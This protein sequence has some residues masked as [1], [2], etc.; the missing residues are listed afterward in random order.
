M[1]PA[2]VP[3]VTPRKRASRQVRLRRTVVVVA[4]A[5]AGG[6][7]FAVGRSPTHAS[8][9]N[10]T[11]PHAAPT[12]TN[13]FVAPKQPS[14]PAIYRE[15]V[16][17]TLGHA[18]ADP[19]AGA[20]GT[21]VVFAGGLDASTTSTARIGSISGRTVQSLANLPAAFHDSAGAAIDNAL[22]L[23]GGGN[24][25]SQL[26]GIV[27]VDPNGAAT[28]VGR[29]P[30]PS[31]DSLAATIG[32]TAYVVG[33]YTGAR[34]LDTIVAYDPQ[35][36][37]RIVAHL[38]VGLRYAAVAAAGGRIV[39]AGG[40][41]PVA[42]AS[43]TIYSFDPASG[44]VTA[45]GE[46]PQPISHAAAAGVGNE[47]L[48]AGG[49][50]IADQPQDSITAINPGTHRVRAAGRLTTARSDAALVVAD[51]KPLLIG[52]KSA[53]STL[54][55]VSELV[56][57]D[58]ATATNV[59]AHDT[60]NALSPVAA[61]ARPLIY[62]PNSM[63][64]TVDVIDP[65]TYTVI[66]QFNVGALPQHV[67]PAW[68][69]RT[70]YVDNDHGNSLTPI[71]PRTGK[72]RGPD[73]P[74][75]D[76]YNLYFTTDG[77]DAI[78]VAEARGR[79]DFRDP[80]SFKLVKSVPVPC[81]GVD[82]MDYTA[83]GKLALA[84][85]EFSGQMI[86]VD[87]VH[88]SILRRI[89]LPDR[90]SRPRPQDV[91]LSPDGRLFYVA[92]MNAGGV[93]EIDAR[94]FTVVRFLAT[95]AGAHGLYPSRDA[96]DLYV[97]NR[98]AGTISVIDFAQRTIVKTW[99]IPGGSPDMGGVSADGKVLWLSGRFSSSVY[100]IST[101]DGHVIAT[102]KVGLG[103]HGLCVWPQPGRYSI[104]HTGITR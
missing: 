76:P 84:S 50:N 16:V 65:A 62:V 5:V 2:A 17:L 47:M 35:H 102:I 24:G 99:T 104:G 37:A 78:V 60:A 63:S 75:T 18:V 100:A 36:G 19:A 101:A 70:L 40:S 74:V 91:K 51:G 54:N 3:P 1:R 82:H 66:D 86:V 41:T 96:R 52:G 9:S 13:A 23:F 43:R 87:V 79:L 97:T 30:A 95:G 42:S 88:Q 81:V 59:Y 46:L 22:Y 27:R 32:H 26:D 72:R 44:A 38:P 29:L 73:I 93:W 64:N 94:T 34:W 56:I 85:C 39:I 12:T 45:I 48:I 11:A 33:G 71:D 15:V 103:P 10:T 31:S 14:A 61:A 4:I 58:R 67:T 53:T 21:N 90:G 68:D 49:L 20:L 28:T 80:H 57:E 7:A 8:V 6:L 89:D 92:D 98:A 83:D 69:L 25:V 55:T 77:R